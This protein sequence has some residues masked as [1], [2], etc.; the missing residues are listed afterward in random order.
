MGIIRQPLTVNE[1]IQSM[2][3]LKKL[4]HDVIKIQQSRKLG[5]DA[6]NF[7]EVGKGWWQGF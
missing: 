4:Q 2:N 6:F 1:G 7:G 5:N 3:S